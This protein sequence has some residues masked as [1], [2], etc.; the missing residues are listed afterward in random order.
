MRLTA[1]IV[2]YRTDRMEL[3][4]CLDLLQRNGVERTYVV[5]NSPEDSL[6]TI[7]SDFINAEYI[8]RPDNPGYGV[9][10]NEALRRSTAANSEYHLVINSDISFR[11]DVLPALLSFMDRH[12]DAGQI[13]PR[14]IYPDGKEQNSARLIPTPLDLLGRRFIPG[15][16]NMARNRRYEL[17]DRPADRVLNIPYHQ[18]CF[19]L[20]RM[21]ALRHVGMFD[22]RFFMYPEDIDMTRRVH[23]LYPTI[24]YPH[25]T[26]T[27]YHRASSYKSLRMLW[28]HL[29]N[30]VRYFNKWGWFH[31]PLRRRFNRR[32]LEEINSG[33]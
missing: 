19:M 2:T 18:G 14:I 4:K 25:V 32:A 21:S 23:E 27:H 26:I 8:P 31:D 24:Y 16:K 6:K 28:I 12:P 9:A 7:V 1:S 17:A 20:F 5:D 13:Q 30:M 3:R 22:E 15:W 29:I 11:P 10:H 33:I